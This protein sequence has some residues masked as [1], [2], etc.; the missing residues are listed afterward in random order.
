MH[1]QQQHGTIAQ[2]RV[3]GFDDGA[4]GLEISRVWRAGFDKF[5]AQGQQANGDDPAQDFEYALGHPESNHPDCQACTV[6]FHDRIESQAN[7]GAGDTHQEYEECLNND[8]ALIG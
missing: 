5:L 1:Q 6:F 8:L 4:D 2:P 7:P 3:S